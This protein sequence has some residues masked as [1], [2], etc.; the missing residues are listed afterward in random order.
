MFLEVTEEYVKS[1]IF[2]WNVKWETGETPT[3]LDEKVGVEGEL[4]RDM[5]SL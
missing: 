5:E 1:S 4:T 2:F 3:R